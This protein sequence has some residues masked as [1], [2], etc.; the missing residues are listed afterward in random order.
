M[1]VLDGQRREWRRVLHEGVVHWVTPD[2]D[3]L[4]LGDGRRIPEATARYLAPCEPSK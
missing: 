2:T 1:S 4:V 3:E